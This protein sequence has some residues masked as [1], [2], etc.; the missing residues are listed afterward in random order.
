MHDTEFAAHLSIEEILGRVAAF[1]DGADAVLVALNDSDEY[2]EVRQ[3]Y[4]LTTDDGK[5]YIVIRTHETDDG[6]PI[7]SVDTD[8]VLA[9]LGE[10]IIVVKPFDGQRHDDAEVM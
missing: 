5:K 2:L 6:E 1:G 7:R 10:V 8:G 4:E 9:R 3:A